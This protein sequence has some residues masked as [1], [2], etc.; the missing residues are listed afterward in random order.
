E[1]ILKQVE[2]TPDAV[3]LV[4]QEERLSYREIA[5]RSAR[6][7]VRL[8]AAGVGPEVPVGVCLDRTPALLAS[9]LGVMRAGGFYVPLD[10]SYPAERLAAILDDSRARVL[11][12]EERCLPLLPE[13][14]ARIVRADLEEDAALSPLP[15]LEGEVRSSR[16]AYT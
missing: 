4:D 2:R 1:L 9:L 16:L 13:T 8:R 3:A 12:T 15:E 10:P 6:M 11:V 5:E 14:D 7:A